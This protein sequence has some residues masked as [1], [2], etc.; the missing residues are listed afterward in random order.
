MLLKANAVPGAMEESLPLAASNDH[1]ARCGVDRL[2]AHPR[3]C[4]GGR[5]SVRTLHELIAAHEIGA[6]WHR[7]ATPR[8]PNGT[9]GVGAVAAE[10]STNVEHDRVA[11]I[12]DARAG[13]MVRRRGVGARGN[14]RKRRDLVSGAGESLAHL[15]RHVAL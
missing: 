6:R 12:D 14:D 5:C 2:A 13:L 1:L 15:A 4:R 8:H 10:L 3:L 9:R 11:R 7:T